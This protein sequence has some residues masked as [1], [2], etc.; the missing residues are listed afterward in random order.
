[1]APNHCVSGRLAQIPQY[2][3]I[4]RVTSPAL[5]HAR[6]EG[7]ISKEPL[8]STTA[9]P[10]WLDHVRAATQRQCASCGKPYHHC[11]FHEH[12]SEAHGGG[13]CRSSLDRLIAVLFVTNSAA[14][15]IFLSI[16]CWPGE[17]RDAPAYQPDSRS[18]PP[19][20]S[21]PAH[22]PVP[23][24]HAALLRPRIWHRRTNGYVCAD[25]HRQRFGPGHGLQKFRCST[26][27]STALARSDGLGHQEQGGCSHVYHHYL[28]RPL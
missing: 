20:Q 28:T 17:W 10:P 12:V 4:F 7:S 18:R 14:A 15:R 19:Q 5:N 22:Q 21:S 16:I 6:S 9:K 27:T 2:W 24:V 3:H 8:Q 25:V 23:Y 13:P 26:T 11:L 1:M